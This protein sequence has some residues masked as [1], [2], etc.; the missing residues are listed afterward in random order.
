MNFSNNRS[1]N[2]LLLRVSL[3][4]CTL[5]I[6]VFGFLLLQ[7][8]NNRNNAFATNYNAGQVIVEVNKQRVK[9]GLSP[10]KINSKLM[11]SGTNK[12]NHMSAN[13]YFSHIGYGKKWSDFIKESGY[14]YAEAGENLANGFDNVPDMVEAWMN[15]PTHRENILNPSVDETGIGVAMGTLDG[16][17]TIFVAQVFGRQSKKPE[18]PN[19]IIVAPDPQP[20]PQTQPGN[21]TPN[22]PEKQP[23]KEPESIEELLQLPEITI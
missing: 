23:E 3:I 16:A 21:Q 9:F 7:S 2:A 18:Q 14:D 11:I 19:P 12:A 17:Q 15:S 8:S 20:D 13:S 5:S 10:L 4:V 6:A 1:V 22:E